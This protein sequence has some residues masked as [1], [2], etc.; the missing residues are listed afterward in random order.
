[1][2]LWHREAGD[3]AAE[4]GGGG[5]RL[6]EEEAWLLFEDLQR[7][8]DCRLQPDQ[9][10]KSSFDFVDHYLTEHGKEAVNKICLVRE[11]GSCLKRVLSDP[12]FHKILRIDVG[13]Q[14]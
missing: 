1:M 6:L 5:Q 2:L 3:G 7:R 10:L 4:Q 8:L 11:G 14:S 12:E 9:I 13:K